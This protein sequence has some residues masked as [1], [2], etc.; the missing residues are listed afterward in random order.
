VKNQPKLLPPQFPL[1]PQ[2]VL[3]PYF[4]A[5]SPL[6][7]QLFP[8][9]AQAN[10]ALIS[11]SG[12]VVDVSGQPLA[13]ATVH[14][15]LAD[16]SGSYDNQDKNGNPLQ[17]PLQQQVYRGRIITDSSGNYSFACLRPGNYFDGGWNLWRPAHIHVL[18]E[19]DDYEEL[20]TQ[21]Y[22]Q[23]DPQNTHDIPGD[24]FFHPELVVQLNP[25][26][27]SAGQVQ[28]GIFNFVLAKAN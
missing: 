6:Q 16:P 9:Q 12:Q 4:L 23:D 24:G 26:K 21:L 13:G 2:Q 25:A 5:N 3:G 28:K 15:W 11:I 10:G 7:N 20:V 17:I 22:F 27:H 18:V 14:V 19:A 1:T 8:P